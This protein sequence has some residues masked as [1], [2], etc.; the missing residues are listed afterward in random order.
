MTVLVTHDRCCVYDN[1]SLRRREAWQDGR[2]IAWIKA[3]VLMQ[4]GF[5]G[6]SRLPFMLNV[7][8]W[9]DGQIVGDAA[10]LDKRSAID[11]A[12][13]ELIDSM[14]RGNHLL[15]IGPGLKHE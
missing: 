12:L 2:L 15:R 8:S 7:G 13:W 6:H 4:K 14:R 1:P 9:K 5:D 10:A 3:I 11:R